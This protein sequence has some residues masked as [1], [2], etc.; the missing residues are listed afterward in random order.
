MYVEKIR[1]RKG[2]VIHIDRYKLGDVIDWRL[3]ETVRVTAP[4]LKATV[5]ESTTTDGSY[6][7]IYDGPRKIALVRA[8]EI[9]I[10][11][12]GYSLEIPEGAT[13]SFRIIREI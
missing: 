2:Q 13:H 10:L 1:N 5:K 3:C 9:D 11:V 7:T 4:E 12:R 6:I 8:K